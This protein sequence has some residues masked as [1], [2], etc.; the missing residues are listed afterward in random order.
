MALEASDEI[1][2]FKGAFDAFDWNKSGTISYGSLQVDQISC[3]TIKVFKNHFTTACKAFSVK[4]QTR[5]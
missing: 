3:K 4:N 5:I 1:G 2:A